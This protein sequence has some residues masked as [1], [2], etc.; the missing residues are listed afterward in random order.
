MVEYNVGPRAPTLIEVVHCPKCGT[1]NRAPEFGPSSVKA[2]LTCRGCLAKPEVTR[3]DTFLKPIHYY[4]AVDCKRCRFA[5]TLA[6]TPERPEIKRAKDMLEPFM[7]FCPPCGKELEYQPA[8]VVVWSGPPPTS[9]FIAHPAFLKLR[10][11]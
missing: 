4:W 3:A 8:D 2:Q 11:P 9:A 10:K 6:E 7:A 5:I 1:L